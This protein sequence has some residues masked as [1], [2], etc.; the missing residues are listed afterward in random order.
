VKR[1]LVIRGGAIGDFILTLPALKALRDAYPAAH[2]E[3]LGYARVADLVKQRFYF[4]E[5]RSIEYAALA[6]FFGKG[7]PLDGELQ[8]YFRSFDLI[9]SYLYDPDQI[10]ENNLR[11]AGAENIVIGPGKLNHNGHATEQLTAPMR[12]LDVPVLDFTP[13]IFVS[14]QD[15]EFRHLFVQGMDEPL[16]VLHPGSGGTHKNWPIA[17]WIE[18]GHNLLSSGRSLIVLSGEADEAQ[19]GEL[20]RTW[21]SR[22]VRFA[23]NLALNQVAALLEHS[24]FIGH[25]SGISHLA[26]AVGAKCLLLFGPTDPNIWAPRHEDVRIV[27]AP[28]GDLSQ[29]TVAEVW[30][31]IRSVLLNGPTARDC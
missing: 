17:R 27:R 9:I 20:R 28:N 16:V 12:E 29:L 5:V 30:R 26:A 7:T 3:L 1:I 14:A 21:G 23:R 4:N 24:R 31:A 22:S 25:D 10:F 19:T 18:I 6:G 2:I 11:R 8:S 15:R 13:R